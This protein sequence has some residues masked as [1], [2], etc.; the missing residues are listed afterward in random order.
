[1]PIIEQQN[2]MWNGHDVSDYRLNARIIGWGTTRPSK[3]H[4]NGI[5]IDTLTNKILVNIGTTNSPSWLETVASA[6]GFTSDALALA[7]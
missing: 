6:E 2:Y 3:W 5:F 4:I 1:M 7:G